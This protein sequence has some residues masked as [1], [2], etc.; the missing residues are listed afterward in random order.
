M[1][2][3]T[4][5]KFSVVKMTETEKQMVGR[6]CRHCFH[7]GIQMVID[8]EDQFAVYCPSCDRSTN[9]ETNRMAIAYA[10]RSHDV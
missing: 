9:T 6:S 3:G 5:I 2:Q 7:T 10:Y 8:T 1:T 4:E